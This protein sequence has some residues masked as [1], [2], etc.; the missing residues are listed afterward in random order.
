MP[1]R[2]ALFHRQTAMQSS[3]R[4][5]TVGLVSL[6]CA[7][8]AVDLQVM[9]GALLMEEIDL[10]SDPDSAD[11]ILV[12]T[13]AFI[14][15]AR[16]EAND[17]ILRACALKRRGR[18]RFVVVSGCLPQRYG[19][20][21]AA[22]YPEVDAWI[23]IDHLFDLPDL[24]RRLDANG[25]AGGRAEVLV[26]KARN[27]LYEPPIPEFTITGGA[28][29]YLKIAEGCSH[30][31]AYCAIPGIRGRLRSRHARDILAEARAL[32]RGGVRELDIV[33]QD[34]TAYGRDL[35]DG[36]D[37]VS[38]LARLDRM[39]GDFRLRLLYGYPAYVTDALLDAIASSRKVCR[40]IDVPVQH[41]HPDML[42]A[43][44]RADTVGH[45]AGMAGRIRAKC[46][47]AAVRTT[48]I[49]GFP[50]ETE[51]H[52][53]HLLDYVSESRFD[54][55]GVFCFSP[56]EG[57]PAAAMDGQVPREVAE[58]RRERLMVAQRAIVA[59]RARKAV[60]TTLRVLVERPGKPGFAVARSEFQAPDVDGVTIVAD[61]AGSLQ[62]GDFATVTVTGHSG[63]DILARPLR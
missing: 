45:V 39:R 26:S 24:I 18:A 36:T 44:R 42:R 61:K 32:V 43:M 47:G 33:G 23:G 22:K 56:E 16:D 17:E 51:E 1:S 49:V 7:K 11:V 28:H 9:G 62:A 48:L 55:L 20:S 54:N 41:S 3:S 46:P 59:E 6:G 15:A 30:T 53:S 34:V 14:Q 37:L 5:L 38:L 2:I 4:A 35:R 19:S 40:Y 8:N 52:F 12:N 63:Y 57:T 21:L 31:C 27:T 50:G 58:E 13:C 60:G 25:R 10:A 29:A